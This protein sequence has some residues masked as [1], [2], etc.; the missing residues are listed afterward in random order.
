MDA[1]AASMSSEK[2]HRVIDVLLLQAFKG[3]AEAANHWKQKAV[4]D[5]AAEDGS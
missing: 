2:R 1:M 5:M 3:D 4:A